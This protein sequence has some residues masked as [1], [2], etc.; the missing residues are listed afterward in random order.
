[1]AMQSRTVAQM[2]EAAGVRQ[3]ETVGTVVCKCA[4]DTKTAAASPFQSEVA[5]ENTG[6][7]QQNHLI[8]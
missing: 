4:S 2:N 8:W 5:S 3:E 1:M 7:V 6:M